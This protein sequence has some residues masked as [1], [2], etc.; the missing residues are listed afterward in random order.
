MSYHSK[1]S[2]AQRFSGLFIVIGLHVV[3]LV[4]L[5]VGLKPKNTEI[6]VEDVKVETKEEVKAEQEAPPPPPPDFVPPPPPTASLPEFNVADA[7]VAPAN[8][9][10]TEVPKAAPT[11]APAAC[12]PGKPPGNKGISLPPYPSES[13]KL[14]EEGSVL[15][16]VL[17]GSDGKVMDSKVQATSGFTRLDEAVLKES[18]KW[19]NFV[20]CPEPAWFQFKLTMKLADAK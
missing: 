7:P 8:A 17:I 15:I 9:I 13:K 16:A 4:G 14:G 3:V 1:K 20:G 2:F 6:V 10:R 19:K 11:P 12:V 18:K 5:V